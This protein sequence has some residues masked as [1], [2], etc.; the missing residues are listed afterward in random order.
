MNQKYIG[1][2][3]TILALMW[4]A[5][6][7]MSDPAS[8]LKMFASEPSIQGPAEFQ[9]V[10]HNSLGLIEGKSPAN[11]Q[12]ICKYVTEVRYDSSPPTEN[13]ACW[14]EPGTGE[15][16][17]HVNSGA[18][19]KVYTSNSVSDELKQYLMPCWLCHETRHLT[20]ISTYGA[21]AGS[22]EKESGA[23]DAEKEF[24]QNA[25]ASPDMTNTIAGAYQLQTRWW[26]RVNKSTQRH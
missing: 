11:Y 24:M 9:K 2:L 17:I 21:G 1:F 3:I 15:G 20:Q 8:T 4:L 10:I 16:I 14:V 18:F 13:V 12:E 26:E 22:L 19:D 7:A 25:G 23:L 5:F 6:R